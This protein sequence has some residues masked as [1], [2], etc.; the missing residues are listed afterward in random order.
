MRKFVLSAWL[1]VI[2]LGG[3]LVIGQ[4]LLSP[5]I[6]FREGVDYVQVDALVTDQAGNV[7]RGLTKEDFQIFEDGKRQNVTAL[8]FIDLPIQRPFGARPAA[9]PA[10]MPPEP[11]VKTNIGGGRVYVI[12]LDDLHTNPLNSLRVKTAARKFIDEYLQPGDRAAIVY[13]SGRADASQEFTDSSRLLLA[14]VDKFVGKK[15]RSATLEQLDAYQRKRDSGQTDANLGNTPSGDYDPRLERVPDPLD[16]ERGYQ[17]ESALKTLKG[18]AEG[19]E[20][21]AGR[22]KAILFISE[23]VDY[24]INDVFHNAFA[25]QVI[26]A[27]RELVAAAARSNVNVYSLDPRGLSLFG[28]GVMELGTSPANPNVKLGTASLAFELQLSEDSLRVLAEQTGGF[29]SVSSNDF[30]GWYERVVRDNSSYY[31]LGYTP[32]DDRRDD[33]FRR[34][35][36]KVTRSG[37][38]VRARQGYVRSPDASPSSATAAM[39]DVLQTPL[40]LAGMPM[41]VSAAAFKGSTPGRASVA[42]TVQVIGAPLKFEQKNGLYEDTIEIVTIAIDQYGKAQIGDKQLVELRLKPETYRVVAASGFRVASRIE[43]TAGRHQLRLGAREIGTNRMGSVHYD[44]EVPDYGQIPL[45]L[46]GV[47]ISSKRATL[48]PTA[49]TDDKLQSILGGPPTTARAFAAGDT[50]T[51]YVELYRAGADTGRVDLETQVIGPDDKVVFRSRDEVSASQ[52]QKAGYGHKFD[53]PLSAPAGNYLLR[54]AATPRTS[55]ASATVREV[56]F[57]VVVPQRAPAAQ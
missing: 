38:T 41:A 12:V 51:A 33:R 47:S 55:N 42:V 27:T 37:L 54:I 9:G 8:S 35:E 32:L 34:I 26:G 14:S 29:A 30:T 16:F 48:L 49:R 7:V 40:P 2:W 25:T 57:Y 56:P 3:T 5:A 36:V 44:L 11:D 43:L 45:A 53:V 52:L 21:V 10:Q 6:T 17:A 50:L 18:V 13:T 39:D 24:D 1:I 15:L 22:R 4:Q 23:G 19:L 20:N 31:M 46:S 28:D